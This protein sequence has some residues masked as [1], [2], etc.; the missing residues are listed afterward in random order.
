MN[1]ERA[2]WELLYADRVEVLWVL[3]HGDELTDA[4]LAEAFVIEENQIIPTLNKD[5]EWVQEKLAKMPRVR[6]FVLFE[7]FAKPAGAPD[8]YEQRVLEADHWVA[9]REPW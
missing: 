1:C 3:L 5:M 4:E 6:P 7:L 9:E 8:V 2:Q